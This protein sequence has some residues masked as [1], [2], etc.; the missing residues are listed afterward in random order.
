MRTHNPICNTLFICIII[1][2]LIFILNWIFKLHILE[3]F[4]AKRNDRIRIYQSDE[5][6]DPDESPE[7]ED[8]DPD[9]NPLLFDPDQQPFLD[10]QLNNVVLRRIKTIGK[11]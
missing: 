8:I 9:D 4:Y 1:I 7:I 3:G 2:S 10:N 6:F 5:I 11:Y